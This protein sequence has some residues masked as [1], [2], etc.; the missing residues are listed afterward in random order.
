[1]ARFSLSYRRYAAWLTALVV[2]VY[3]LFGWLVY[4]QYSEAKQAFE[5][6]ERE[7]AQRELDVLLQRALDALE[8]RADE[9]AQWDELYQQLANPVYFTYWYAHRIKGGHEVPPPF[10]ALM[11]Y[12]VAGRALGKETA[13]PLPRT[14]AEREPTMIFNPAGSDVQV[15]LVRPLRRAGEETPQGFLMLS[16]RLLPNVKRGQAFVRVDP[17]S[18]RFSLD[19]STR[20]PET[21]RRALTYQPRRSDSVREGDRLVRRMLFFIGLLVL[22][23]TLGL[24]YFFIY[25]IG[26][27]IQHMPE[28]VSALRQA[29]QSG[30]SVVLPSPPSGPR[31]RE[32]EEAEH[33][34]LEY[35]RELT[36]ANRQLDKKNRELWSLAHLDA[37]TGAQNRRAFEN[38][39][40]TLQSLGERERRSLRLML[41]DVNHFKAINDTYGHDVGDGVLKAIVACLQ[42]AVRRG[43]QLFRL[44]GDEFVSVL[45][46]C[47]DSQ[48][49]A[50]ASRCA[51]E[52]ARYPFRETLGI[53]E[54]VRLSIGISPATSDARTPLNRLLRQADVAM[55]HSKRPS[56]GTI[57]L[58]RESLE[59]ASGS[60]FSSSV[61]EAVYRAVETGEGLHLLYQP[62]RMLAD[63]RIGYYEALLRV[64]HEDGLLTPA[65]IMP[66]IE[67]RHLEKELDQ[68][69]IDALLRA[70]Y[71]G[72]IPPETG[73]SLNLS[74]ASISSESIVSRLD[75]FRPFLPGLKI[76]V[77]VT[78]TALITRMKEASSNLMRLRNQGFRIALDDFG[79]GYSSLRYLTSMPV[80]VVK[81]D[82]SLISALDQPAHYRLVTHLVEFIGSSGHQ[83]VAEGVE[84][85]QTLER[86]REAGFS[87]VQGYL[88][89]RPQ[90]LR[91]R[92]PGQLIVRPA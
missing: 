20:E 43:E 60:I 54:P 7:A 37:L 45:L 58:Y 31:I 40:E 4:Q 25:L 88:T 77:E 59:Q 83:T 22:L 92:G 36:L 18:L 32:L 2:F 66:V 16:A 52:V 21:L 81:F 57:T 85:E 87:L 35:Q 12:D 74:A 39:W 84:D 51:A 47:D 67:S 24:V 28:V 55:Y 82:I 29:Q 44:G 63:N 41:C 17:T 68:A 38:F 91:P 11:L 49:T 48:A 53:Q 70:L 26:R 1:M 46:D 56:S 71:N 80:D 34:L 65:Q 78:E 61:N 3:G 73:L 23:P 42:K 10:E 79:S 9:L 8:R 76:V 15:F 89:G 62:V 27:N 75:A 19:G 33:S 69:V 13:S 5:Q 72:V 50:V 6:S 64:R 90:A 30:S 86:V 14:L